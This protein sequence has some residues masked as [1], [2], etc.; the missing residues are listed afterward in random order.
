MTKECANLLE[1]LFR[2]DPDMRLG[3]KVTK[4]LLRVSK[5]SSLILGSLELIG[6]QSL[7]KNI[8]LHLCPFS[9]ASKT[10]PTTVR[11]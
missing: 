8:S 3:M 5:K 2:K 4:Q 6:R 9:R 7:P 11:Q 10:P 1:G